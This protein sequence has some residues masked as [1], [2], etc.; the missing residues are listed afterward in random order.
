MITKTQREHGTLAKYKVEGCTCPACRE[1]YNDWARN[2]RRNQAYGRWQPYTDAQPVRDHVQQLINAG[3]NWRHVAKLADV[4]T[5][6]VDKLLYGR[7]SENKAPSKGLRPEFASR[8]MA[9]Q[10]GPGTLPRTNGTGFRRRMQALVRKGWS[11]QR[12]AD[13]LGCD[14]RTLRS[15]MTSQQ[16]PTA[17]DQAG[18]A[19]YE[20]LWRLEP[21][22][23]GLSLNA[24]SVARGWAVR[25]GWATVGC[26]DDD[27]IDDPAAIPNWT[28][29][30]G[31]PRGY[32][33]HYERGIKPACE[34]CRAARA[35][36]S[37]AKQQAA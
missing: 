1:A 3:I 9:V 12:L 6:V 22:D 2:R 33:L 17:T 30:C 28:G 8:L 4:S 36:E 15:A 7:P 14:R 34:A 27:T 21:T 31:T 24:V 19:L 20:Q 10:A 29:R 32:W 23:H 25:R 18:R 37:T 11:L 35:A 16:I 26:W 13:E 5:G